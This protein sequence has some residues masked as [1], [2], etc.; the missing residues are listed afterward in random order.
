M[1][2]DE[3]QLKILGAH[4]QIDVRALQ[5][6][7]SGLIDLLKAKVSD[8][9]VITELE[10]ASATISI[11]PLDQELDT[12]RA[13]AEITDGMISL[14]RIA[15]VPDS[16]NTEMVSSLLELAA[17]G[18]LSGV[19]GIQLRCGDREATRVDDRELRDNARKSLEIGHLSIG[20]VRGTVDRFL[21]RDGRREFGLKDEATGKSVK[22][23][24]T[25]TLEGKVVEAIRHEVIAWGDLRRDST[26]RKLSLRLDDL[27]VVEPVGEPSRI[28]DMVGVLGDDWKDS[29]N[30]AD[31]VR[32]Q[33]ER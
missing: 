8:E 10:A 31:W 33:R 5:R 18:E 25:Q 16:W 9:W 20:S 23:T 15:G 2:R 1:E 21:S 32:G 27:E 19:E 13:F 30:S 29:H 11:R 24:F 7:L 12:E 4:G 3:V 6:C 17:P 14:R 22:V 28:R 26:G